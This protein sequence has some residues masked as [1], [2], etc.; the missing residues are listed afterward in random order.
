MKKKKLKN[1]YFIGIGKL[2][3][4]NSYYLRGRQISNKLN[5]KYD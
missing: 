5:E 3:K 1:I 2:N 4:N